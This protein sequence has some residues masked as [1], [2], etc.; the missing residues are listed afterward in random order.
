MHAAE[1]AK[2]T[3]H[4]HALEDR[5]CVSIGEDEGT[6]NSNFAAFNVKDLKVQHLF[7]GVAHSAGKPTTM[8]VHDSGMTP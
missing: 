7:L 4:E 1:L 6:T 8:T 5:H 2:S 3:W